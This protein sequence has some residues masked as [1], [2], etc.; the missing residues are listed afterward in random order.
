MTID[1]T[2]C[3]ITYNHQDYIERAIQSVVEQDFVGS[4][5]LIIG[6]D[7]GT[8]E[9]L[10]VTY[11]AL[12]KH[13]FSGEVNVITHTQNIGG[14]ANYR[15]VHQNA[16][17]K[18]VSHLDGDDFF[19]C[20][21]KT[22]YQLQVFEQHQDVNVVF[23][24]RLQDCNQRFSDR[25]YFYPN[26]V[27]LLK[28]WKGG[29]FHSSKMYRNDFPFNYPKRDFLDKELHFI[30]ARN[31]RVCFVD[32]PLT[33]YRPNIGTSVDRNMIRR[34][35]RLSNKKFSQKLSFHD[36]SYLDFLTYSE[37]LKSKFEEKNVKD[38]NRLQRTRL[39]FNV[40]IQLKR[41]KIWFR[42]IV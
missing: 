15:I 4:R 12:E 23:T 41:L 42:R 34:L 9:T 40:Y 14:C 26:M 22:Q 3:I 33:S 18:Y 20:K 28:N 6:V 27:R 2:F 30:H 19:S 39:R 8:D 5:E 11:A 16:R 13:K 36:A 37:F 7:K 32:S 10:K 25:R 17:G 38:L 35:F 21:L 29:D 24:G 1:V 31:G